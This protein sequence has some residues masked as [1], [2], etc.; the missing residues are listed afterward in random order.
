MD[1]PA[2]ETMG[3][4]GITKDCPGLPVPVPIGTASYRV[5]SDA[6]TSTLSWPDGSTVAAVVVKTGC[7]VPG[8]PGGQPTWVP[9]GI[10]ISWSP[11]AE[12]VN[13]SMVSA[14]LGGY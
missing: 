7:G 6:G 8:T 14:V 4:L 5:T 3:A 12:R 10:L 11:A 9:R 2:P 13:S 1:R